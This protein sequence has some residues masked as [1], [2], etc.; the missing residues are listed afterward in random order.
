[1]ITSLFQD[2]ETLILMKFANSEDFKQTSFDSKGTGLDFKFITFLVDA[3]DLDYFVGAPFH[4]DQRYF[5]VFITEARGRSVS[6]RGDDYEAKDDFPWVLY[7]TGKG[8][9]TGA[10]LRFETKD[11]VMEWL[12]A[13][14]GKLVEEPDWYWVY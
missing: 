1:M 14:E 12:L 11:A 6:P 7:F 5:G 13:T 10:F 9:D 2:T 3:M 8:D 4:D